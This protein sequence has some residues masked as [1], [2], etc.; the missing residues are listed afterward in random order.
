MERFRII[1]YLVLLG[2]SA[3]LPGCGSGGSGDSVAGIDRGGVY[4]P[5]TGFGSVIVNG[6]HYETTSAIININGM[7]AT[8]A[9]LEV[10]YVV[11]MQANLP[12]DGST[13]QAVTIDFGHNVIGPLSAV[14]VVDNQITVL[15]QIVTVMDTTSYDSGIVPASIDGLVLLPIGSILRVSGFAGADGGI[16]ATRV[17]LGNSGSDLEVTGVVTN[18]N[19][20]AQTL[21]VGGLVV[22]YQS[23]NLQNFPTGQPANGDR[24]K[25]EGSTLGVGGV[26]VARELEL[27]E[28][29]LQLDENDELEIEGLITQ[30]T[31]ATQLS[32]SGIAVST[33]SM[34][35]F[36]KGDATMLA[37]NVRVEVEGQLDGNGVLKAS[38]VEFSPDGPLRIE[39]TVDSV[40]PLLVLGILIETDELTVFEDKSPAEMRP[41]SHA[42]IIPTDPL[43][44]AG[45]ESPT[46][47]GVVIATSITRTEPL[48]KIELRGV[49]KNVVAPGF[50][51]LG[52]A[53]LTNGTTDLDSNFF[54]V[55]EGRLV[56][57]QGSLVSGSFV[58]ET[59][60]FKD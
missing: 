9:D 26:L 7:P 42:D 32:V 52:V 13:P 21:E 46:T 33:D 17:E 58:A 34:T 55:A 28:I 35:V 23:A 37:L 49:A 6:R 44:V 3:L 22:D 2:A 30:F 43:E 16:L 31:S 41:F 15:G 57:A 8:E 54:A 53:I 56:E 25:A 45:Y 19:T 47:P 60:E 1:F 38:K 50:S 36:E 5:I 39:A 27:K 51:I 10:G 40:T 48:E 24:V 18:L 11:T 59:V 14:S 29:E 20:V 4:G 12:Q